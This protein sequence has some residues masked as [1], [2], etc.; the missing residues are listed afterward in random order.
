MSS[1]LA[2]AL[3]LSAKIIRENNGNPQAAFY[4]IDELRRD[5]AAQLQRSHN[6]YIFRMEMGYAAAMAALEAIVEH[7]KIIESV[8]AC[9]PAMEW[10]D[11]NNE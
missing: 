3:E 2:S 9:A 7:Q 1:G 4:Q 6:D 8:V 5:L 11:R 10:E